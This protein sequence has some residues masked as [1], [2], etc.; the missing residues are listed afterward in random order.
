M[1]RLLKGNYGLKRKK[2]GKAKKSGTSITELFEHKAFD[3]LGG[4]IAF[5]MKSD[6]FL[7]SPDEKAK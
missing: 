5:V 3:K 2:S 7:W 6:K 1:S 4:S